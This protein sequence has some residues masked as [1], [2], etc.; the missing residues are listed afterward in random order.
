[1][2][3]EYLWTFDI[4]YGLL[5]ENSGNL[6]GTMRFF[7]SFDL[8]GKL[9]THNLTENSGTY[10]YSVIEKGGIISQFDFRVRGVLKLNLVIIVSP[11]LL[12]LLSVSPS[13]SLFAFMKVELSVERKMQ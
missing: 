4:I 12:F 5:S 11:S 9:E 3:K 6:Q 10:Y 7:L 13:I 8:D 2:H 1:M